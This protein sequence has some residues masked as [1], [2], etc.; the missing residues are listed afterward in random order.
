MDTKWVV[1]LLMVVFSVPGGRL[2]AADGGIGDHAFFK[3]MVGKWTAK[4]ELK[5][6]DGNVQKYQA[7]WSGAMA[8]D[9]SFVVEGTR[10]IGATTQQYRW[11]FTAGGVAGLFEGLHEI[12]N[13]TAS[14]Q[15]F[16]V[17]AAEASMSVEMSA[18]LGSG[19]AK[20]VVKESFVDEAHDNLQTV[21]EFT[22]DQGKVTLSGAINNERQKSL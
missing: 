13:D 8:E 1:C 14:S 19:N 21:V 3:L 11:V 17:S 16:E 12:V 7:E 22:D 15:R 9:G 10:E 4:G 6:A 2:A 20:V 5:G 18:F